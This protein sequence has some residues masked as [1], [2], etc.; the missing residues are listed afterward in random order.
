[1]AVNPPRR[2]EIYMVDLEPTVGS[3][4]RKIRPAIVIQ[5]DVSNRYSPLTIVAAIT[6]SLRPTRYP[7]EVFVPAGEGGLSR[8][9]ILLMNQIRSVDRQRIQKKLGKVS[10]MTLRRTDRAIMISLGLIEE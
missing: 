3:E 10:E 7:T 9:S 2:G 1:M 8:D 5:N 6:S 4:I